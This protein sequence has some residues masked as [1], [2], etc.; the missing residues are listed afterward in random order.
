MRSTRDI[1]LGI[2]F[3]GGILLLAVATVTLSG[4]SL[5]GKAPLRVHFENARGLKAGDAVR[6]AG[7]RFGRVREVTY[8]ANAPP[9]RR[10]V[11]LA[12]LD[13]AVVLREGHTLVIEPASALGGRVL[14][15]DPEGADLFG[16]SQVDAMT[17]MAEFFADNEQD[18][19]RFLSAAANTVERVERGEG[20]IGR[21][22]R[23]EGPFAD[24]AAAAAD[25]RE[26]AEGI[27]T[28]RGTL[29]Q[30]VTNE[31]AYADIAATA[32]SLRALAEGA[33]RGEGALGRLLRDEEMGRALSE[34]ISS[35]REV[36]TTL[37]EGRGSLGKLLTDEALYATWTAVGEDVRAITTALR[38]GKG[39]LGRLVMDEELGRQLEQTFRAI[40][41][42]I[43][44]ARE[45]A[46]IATFAGVLFGV[47]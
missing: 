23:D 10:V 35:L 20:T 41:R 18:V 12:E 19:R 46:P 43:E 3:F 5:R 31:K 13:T 45:A 36:A 16:T 33:E 9:G 32:S 39:V 38:E 6:V 4:W 30:L 8:F 26:I 2:V 24:V 37:R 40:S 47:L 17:A 25:V 21:L 27:R 44:D 15:I 34:A 11:V 1:L 29:G 42:Q 14:E 28:G 7:T 22:L